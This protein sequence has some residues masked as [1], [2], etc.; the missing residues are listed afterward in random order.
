MISDTLTALARG[1]GGPSPVLEHEHFPLPRQ[2]V[3]H[4]DL[5]SHILS[6][7]ASVQFIAGF[8]TI[9]HHHDI[10]TSEM[11]AVPCCVLLHLDGSMDRYIWALCSVVSYCVVYYPASLRLAHLRPR[12]PSCPSPVPDVTSPP[13]HTRRIKGEGTLRK[14]Y[15]YLLSSELN[16]AKLTG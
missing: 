15:R 3:Q 2:V 14:D 8:A 5:V 4:P 9:Y 10:R 1:S 7:T 11:A 13:A 6:L 12:L 16:P